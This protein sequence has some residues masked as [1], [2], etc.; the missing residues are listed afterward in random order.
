MPTYNEQDHLQRTLRSIEAQTYGNIIEVLVADGR[1]SDGT[2]RIASEF[3]FVR[4]VDNPDRIQAAGMN[5]ALDAAQ[6]EIIVRVDGH[7]ELDDDYVER[8]VETL[9]ATGAAMVGG[10]MHP[11]SSVSRFPITQ[12]AIASAMGSRLGAGPAR[13][14]VGETAG[15]VDTV[16]LGAYR[17]A[18]ARAV[19]GYAGEMVV[20]EDA[21]FA[22]RMRPAWRDLVRSAHP[23]DLHP[24]VDVPLA[25]TPVLPVRQGPGDDGIA[26]SAQSARGSS[27]RRLWCS[28]W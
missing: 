5:R 23:V 19:G 4:I 14:H 6:G 27:S 16:Y 11:T 10:G 8:C 28:A 22:I 2:R 9:V 18:D 1:S 24:S 25:R 7:C 13:F 20:N 3:A 26:S 21:E 17:A 12:R 15:W